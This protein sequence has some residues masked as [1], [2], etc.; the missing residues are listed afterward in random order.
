MYSRNLHVT[1]SLP[2]LPGSMIFIAE[3]PTEPPAFGFQ[4]FGIAILSSFRGVLLSR[5]S[6]LQQ[7]T[8]GWRR[9]QL[10]GQKCASVVDSA[11]GFR[12]TAP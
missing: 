1:P 7:F 5:F 10:P 8:R 6:I 11:I 12:Q 3:F 4:N 2:G 9:P